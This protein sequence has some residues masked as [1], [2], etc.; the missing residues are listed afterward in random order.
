MNQILIS[1]IFPQK[2]WRSKSDDN[3]R[4]PSLSVSTTFWAILSKTDEEEEVTQLI[5]KTMRVLAFSFW[6]PSLCL[7]LGAF[8]LRSYVVVVV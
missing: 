2:N 4:R 5:S 8:S 6:L 3:N 7:L 1:L